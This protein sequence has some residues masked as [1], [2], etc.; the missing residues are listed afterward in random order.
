MAS[1]KHSDQSKAP[2]QAMGKLVQTLEL[3]QLEQ[4]LFRGCSP[5]DG[6]QRVFGGQ[7]VGQALRAATLTLTNRFAHSLHAY[8]MR[9]GDPKIPIIYEV[10]LTREGHSFSTRR[11]IAIQHGKP[12]FTMSCSF[13]ME[14]P[15]FAHQIDV[16][17][18]PS[19]DELPTENELRDKLL[20]DMPAPIR[21]YWQRDRPVEVR[22]V[23]ISRYMAPKKASP[24]QHVWLR[25][26]GAL[27]DDLA[28][29]QCAIAFATDISLL[30]TALIPHGRTIFDPRLTLASI[31]HAL[32]FHKPAKF[33]DWV[34]YSTDSPMTHGARGFTRGTLFTRSGELI[35]ST[36]QEGLIRDLEDKV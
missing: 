36:A 14:E 13:H 28:V 30:D 25:P 24:E 22:P 33:D 10:E 31:D 19:P 26:T 18:V 9:P 17:D 27:P 29:H 7:V 5:K 6:W 20:K 4:N 21:A 15:G 34:L 16:P 12:I 2:N 32:W 8:F 3:E 23:D 1:D 11:V 35:A